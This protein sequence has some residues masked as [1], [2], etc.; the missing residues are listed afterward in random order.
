MPF[1]LKSLIDPYCGGLNPKWKIDLWLTGHT[2]RYTRSIP[3]TDEI[4][5]PQ[6]PRNPFFDGSNFTFPV[7]TV[8]GPLNTHC[9]MATA[10][11][12]DVKEDGIAVQSIDDQ[13]RVFESL[14]YHRDGHCDEFLSLP[15]YHCPALRHQLVNP[16]HGLP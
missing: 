4:A 15:H 12:V 1:E 5:A 2:H 6:C 16:K 9:W 10:F 13:G 7:L 8:G 3:R 11:R 14:F